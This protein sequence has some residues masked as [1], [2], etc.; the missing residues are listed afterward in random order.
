MLW[1]KERRLEFVYHVVTLWEL[2]RELVLD[3]NYYQL[4]PLASL[5]ASSTPALVV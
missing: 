4:W 3:T 5:M 1:G 2:L